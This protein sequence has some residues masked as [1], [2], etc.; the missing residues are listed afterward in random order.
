MEDNNAEAELA[1]ARQRLTQTWADPRIRAIAR[2]RADRPQDAEDALQATFLA[3]YRL[4]GLTKIDDMRAYFCRVL[5]REVYRQQLQLGALL[6]DDFA[7]VT[8]TSGTAASDL[9]VAAEGV[10]DAACA[11]V[12]AQHWHRR[13][14]QNR[15]GLTA[16]VPSRSDDPVRYQGMVYDAAEQ[17]LRAGISGEPREADSN[18]AF[19]A[20]YPE[21]FDAPRTAKNTSH[22]RLRRARAD[23]RTL[24]Q[25]VTR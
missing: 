3:M 11:S 22:Q 17:I 2:N 15:E 10:E 18:D 23:V 21:Y 5:T 19:R 8:D 16:R 14:V 13:L 24:L 1:A 7:L 20:A 9:R 4:P 6:V 12:Q 25:H